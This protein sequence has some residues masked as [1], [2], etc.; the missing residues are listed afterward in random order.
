MEARGNEYL[1]F[2]FVN[3]KE[4]GTCVEHKRLHDGKDDKI[5]QGQ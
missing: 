5:S 1:N 4:Y 2:K 3:L